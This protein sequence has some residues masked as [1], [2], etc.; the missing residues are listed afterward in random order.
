MAGK[1][2]RS[3]GC[4][5][6][7]RIPRCTA[8]LPIY[9]GL[10]CS[11]GHSPAGSE[12]ALPMV[13]SDSSTAGVASSSVWTIRVPARVL[14]PGRSGAVPAALVYNGDTPLTVTVHCAGRDVVVQVW[15]LDIGGT[16]LYLSTR[17]ARR[18]RRSTMGLNQPSLTS[19][20][21]P[22]SRP[23]RA[24]RDRLDAWSS[25]RWRLEPVRRAPQRGHAALAPWRWSPRDGLWTPTARAF[26]AARERTVSQPTTP[27]ERR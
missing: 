25:T 8:R 16:P 2:R 14:A 13:A 20:T 15:R 3:V 21:G 7:C 9:A 11:P 27:V 17:S 4:V 12:M 5:S 6:L 18:T 26:H 19:R 10:A 23:V 24:P 22:P 1:A